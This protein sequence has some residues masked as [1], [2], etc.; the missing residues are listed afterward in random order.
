MFS[1]AMSEDNII[2]I[3]RKPPMS[4]VTAVLRSFNSEGNDEV[5][6]KARGQ[7]ISN[8]VDVAEITRNNFIEEIKSPEIEITTEELP[9]REGGTRGVSSITITLKKEISKTEVSSDEIE[10]TSE[11]MTTEEEETQPETEET[12]ETEI[13]E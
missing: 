8:A 1:V 2:Y 12:E 11:E 5:L 6:L 13:I 9:D 7:A 10:D 3:G 4:Y